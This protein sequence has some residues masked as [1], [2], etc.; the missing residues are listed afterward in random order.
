MTTD[1][2]FTFIYCVK[3][4]IDCEASCQHLDS[5]Q[6][7]VGYTATKQI[8]RNNPNIA[9]DYNMAMSNSAAKYKIYLHQ[10]TNIINA[11]FLLEILSLF[12]NHPELGMLGVLG[13]KKLP[14]NGN[15]REASERYGKILFGGEPLIYNNEITSDYQPVQVIDGMI[16][17]TQYDLPWREEVFHDQF[18]Y[19]AAQCL[20]FIK[21]GYKVGIPKQSEPWCAFNNTTDTLI[22]YYRDRERFCQE[23]QGFIG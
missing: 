7:P 2:C 20:E 1:N 9:Q 19:D 8:F 18:F 16:M 23:Y 14:P 6:I 22:Q 4:D 10:Y 3:N 5:L 11:N 12:K 17:I 21:V 13:A 15:W